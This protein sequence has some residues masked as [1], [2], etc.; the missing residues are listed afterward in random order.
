MNYGMEMI[1]RSIIYIPNFK[2]IGIGVQGL[3]GGIHI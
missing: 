1:S 3:L 2:K